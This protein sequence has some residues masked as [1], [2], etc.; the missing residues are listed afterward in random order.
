M[1]RHRRRRNKSC[2][3]AQ[4]S[5]TTGFPKSYAM[6]LVISH[7]Y[8]YLVVC[9]TSYLHT[10]LLRSFVCVSKL[11]ANACPIATR[12]CL[13]THRTRLQFFKNKPV[14]FHF[15]FIHFHTCKYQEQASS[16]SKSPSCFIHF[17]LHICTLQQKYQLL[18]TKM[19]KLYK[20]KT[21]YSWL[22]LCFEC[23]ICLLAAPHHGHHYA[24]D[25]KGRRH[26][27]EKK[28]TSEIS[29]SFFLDAI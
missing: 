22:R 21:N 1:G 16:S 13:K 17:T 14:G 3:M 10:L 8:S 24:E 2:A 19:W 28:D 5:Q 20:R 26:S 15:R 27:F 7:A 4:T 11:I 9:V 6:S 12:V 29:S 23:K 25:S 18:A